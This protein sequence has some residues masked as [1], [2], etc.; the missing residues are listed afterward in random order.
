MLTDYGWKGAEN[1]TLKHD[2]TVLRGNVQNYIKGINFSY[3]A[4]M[5]EIGAD[6]INA[7]A[8]FGNANEVQ[9]KY[10]KENASYTLKAKNFVIAAGNRPRGYPG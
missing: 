3:K 10:G 4:K 1:V 8:S 5:Q 2:W 9:F 7:F 6:Y